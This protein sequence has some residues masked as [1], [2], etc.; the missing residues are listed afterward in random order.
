[1]K[2]HKLDLQRRLWAACFAL[3][4][5]LVSP[6]RVAAEAVAYGFDG[7]SSNNAANEL[8]G[9]NQ[10][11][12]SVSANET[13]AGLIAFRYENIGTEASSITDIYFEDEAL[14]L[15]SGIES[16]AGSAG[17]SFS[18]GARPGNLP[19]GNGAA[20][21]TTSYGLSADSDPPVEINGVNPGEW[22]DL[23][24]RLVESR[25]LADVTDALGSG[26]LRT[27]LHV[28]GFSNG[29]GETF[30]NLP[31]GE[32]GVGVPAPEPVGIALLA[33][34]ALYAA[35][36]KRRGIPNRSADVAQ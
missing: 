26:A 24:L 19:G 9:E 33:C 13:D 8:A 29:G 11:S 14:G 17:V 25:T 15:F 36:R 23:M 35:R 31:D 28:Q 21:F 10:L 6:H 34:T 1:M 30:I 5:A 12:V 20:N 4:A 3:T 27:A 16:I 2:K 7:I 32:S 18:E 22:V